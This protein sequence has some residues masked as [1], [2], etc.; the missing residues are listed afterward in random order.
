M[1]VAARSTISRLMIWR[2]TLDGQ[3]AHD[4]FKALLEAIRVVHDQNKKE[5]G[6][7]IWMARP[8]P[9]K[10][11]ERTRIHWPQQSW[12]SLLDVMRCDRAMRVEMQRRQELK[13]P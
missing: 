2:A 4:D 12:A 11:M 8:I 3:K 1:H 7:V 9:L 10:N 6:K 13:R 5:V